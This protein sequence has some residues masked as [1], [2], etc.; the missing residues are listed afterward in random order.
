LTADEVW[1]RLPFDKQYVV[2]QKNI[3]VVLKKLLNQGKIKNKQ[4]FYFLDEED[5]QN[6]KQRQKYVPLKQ[7]E[8][9]QL[10]PLLHRIPT[11]KA[12]ILTGS[13]AVDNAKQADDLDFMLI[14]QA[15]TLWL[16]R[17]LVTI[18]TKLKHKRP[19]KK[20]NNAWCFNIYLDER[21]LTIPQDRRSLYEA[22]EILQ[23]RYLLDTDQLE[24]RFLA[25]NS[26][27]KQHLSYY[28]Q[29]KFKRFQV[30]SQAHALTTFLNYVLFCVQV[31]Y[32]RLKF[33][34]ELFTL[35]PTQAF[36]N[37]TRY[38]ETIFARMEEKMKKIAS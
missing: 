26:W 3:N 28:R 8:L 18:L 11:L 24:E 34:H 33:G 30:F 12:V 19:L 14:C 20:D 29:M 6:R 4:E 31:F 10:L 37:E 13:T 17:F 5:W 27:L 1:R 2:G 7:T 16:T 36:F 22:Y 32:R 9:A 38:R 25:A 23:M 15:G 35:T 21:D